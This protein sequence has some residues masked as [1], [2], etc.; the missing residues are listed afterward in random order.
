MVL[1]FLY[2][3]FFY[4]P[5]EGL[6]A[7]WY[8]GYL[9]FDQFLLGLLQSIPLILWIYLPIRWVNHHE[10]K[11]KKIAREA[12]LEGDAWAQIKSLRTELSMLQLSLKLDPTVRAHE[13]EWDRKHEQVRREGHHPKYLDSLETEIYNLKSRIIPLSEKLKKRSPEV[14]LDCIHYELQELL[15]Q[16]GLSES[17][18]KALP[19]LIKVVQTAR[20]Y[21]T[22]GA[23]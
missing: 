7:H 8:H 19:R 4:G 18:K 14:M 6:Y 1:K 3:V 5:Y 12:Q 13:N 21:P 2:Y 15:A 17:L 9:D 11:K 20:N 10:D 16:D 22:G 23:K